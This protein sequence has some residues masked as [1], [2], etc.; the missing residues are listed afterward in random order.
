[1]RF[2][3][4]T[5]TSEICK[6]IGLGDLHV[7][8][9]SDRPTGLVS[10][11]TSQ[12]PHP[13]SFICYFPGLFGAVALLDC[14]LLATSDYNILHDVFD[15]PKRT[16]HPHR[17]CRSPVRWPTGCRVNDSS[18]DPGLFMKLP[19]KPRKPSFG[20]RNGLEQKHSVGHVARIKPQPPI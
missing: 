13:Q 17:E 9:N 2:R 8:K 19:Q 1:M 18:Q 20:V 10:P 11:P 4:Q 6:N 16:S 15:A 7:T 3:E 5:K 14:W 12:S